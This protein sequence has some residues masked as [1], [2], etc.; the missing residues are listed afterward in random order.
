MGHTPARTVELMRLEAARRALEG[1]T[2]PVKRIAEVA[3]FGDEQTLRRAFLRQLGIG[4]A[5]YRDRFS[6]HGVG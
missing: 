2:Q 4:P 3:G 6:G 5:Q 1:G